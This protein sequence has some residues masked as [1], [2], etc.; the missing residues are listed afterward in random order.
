M[1]PE[2]SVHIA[3][4]LITGR[5]QEQVPK[6]VEKFMGGGLSTQNMLFI[7]LISFVYWEKSGTNRVEEI[8]ALLR[9]P[10]LLSSGAWSL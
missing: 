7:N 6:G 1:M 3:F 8:L 5:Q 10:E 2:F 4:S 9:I